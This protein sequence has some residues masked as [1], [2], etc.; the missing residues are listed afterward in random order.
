MVQLH[1]C[2][3][4]IKQQS[5]TLWYQNINEDCNMIVTII[6]RKDLILPEFCL[7][8]CLFCFVLLTS[9]SLLL[10]YM[11]TT[12]YFFQMSDLL[13][14]H[15]DDVIDSY[16][17]IDCRYP[18]EFDGGHIQVM[19]ITII[20][21]PEKCFHIFKQQWYGCQQNKTKQT[22]KHTKFWQN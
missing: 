22:N 10:K 4:D 13:R 19:N 12:N 17:V 2:S 15:F 1:N 6:K 20:Y 16:K 21:S 18:Y 8:V 9:I 14:G 11:K 3:L 7:F 5:L